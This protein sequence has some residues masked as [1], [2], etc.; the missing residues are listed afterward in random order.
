MRVAAAQYLRVSSDL[1]NHSLVTQASEI[2][3]YAAMNGFHV[4]K[5]YVD[6][7]K[8]GLTLEKRPALR[9]LMA[10]IAS[11][12]P[13]FDVLLVQDISRWGR[14]QD[15]DEAG[16]YEFLCRMAGVPIHYCSENF[17]NSENPN[18]GL[19]KAVKRL[20]AAEFSR[21]LSGKVRRAQFYW[22]A[23]GYAVAGVPG[24]AFQRVILDEDGS[25]LHY[26]GPGDRKFIA[27]Q[28]T[29]IVWGSPI[30]VETVRRIF[31]LYVD[32]DLT[33]K[34][35]ADTL[36]A[37]PAR[38]GRKDPWTAPSVGRVLSNP[39]YCGRYP[40]GKR[41][42]ILGGSM[43]NLPSEEWLSLEVA[44][45]GMVSESQYLA[46][47]VK[48][49]RRVPEVKEIEILEALGQVIRDEGHIDDA[50]IQRSPVRTSRRSILRKFGS[51]TRIEAMFGVY[52]PAN[53]EVG[54]SDSIIADIER[55][56]TGV[57]GPFRLF[58]GEQ[59]IAFGDSHVI[60]A[61]FRQALSAKLDQLVIFDEATGRIV[62]FD[63]LTEVFPLPRSRSRPFD[64]PIDPRVIAYHIACA[65]LRR[66]TKAK[67]AQ[68]A[69]VSGDGTALAR[70]EPKWSS[71]VSNF[72]LEV[73]VR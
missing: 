20:M 65:F 49:Y 69:L 71:D 11:G 43:V 35:I 5:S 27:S 61:Q 48:R 64:P 37:E 2:A 29:S 23:R 30:E 52:P 10:D 36:N 34:D 58:A 25:A 19:I 40:F 45:G 38:S 41:K 22:A 21:D 53:S 7:G 66:K 8:S 68:K 59:Q 15:T 39:K 60:A 31:R 56:R 73:L 63:S 51:H 28:R 24:Y 3:A 26:L 13:G 1:Q 57:W 62:P 12:K 14:F 32:D 33:I 46:A 4:I 54:A 6:D 17:A 9:E 67:A 44:G 50:A 42:R 47:R 72:I 18:A 70:L 16:H 55:T